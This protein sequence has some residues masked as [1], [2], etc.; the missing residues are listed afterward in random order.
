MPFNQ[1][2]NAGPPR[3]AK[4]APPAETSHEAIYLKSLGDKQTR[5]RVKLVDGE[6]VRGWVE[7]Y[8]RDMIRLT[9]EDQPN[10]F[11]YKHDIIY[12]EEDGGRRGAP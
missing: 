5:V 9:R 11:I 12:I 4:L 7:Y 10:L 3:K 2:G 6:M 8:D 1:R